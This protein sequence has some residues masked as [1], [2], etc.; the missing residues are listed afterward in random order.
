M[1]SYIL[2]IFI[3]IFIFINMLALVGCVQR[4]IPI[5][6]SYP[7][8]TQQKMQSAHHWEVLAEDVAKRLKKTIDIT[9]P[10]ALVK[11]S[12]VIMNPKQ[13][14]TPFVKAFFNL[15]TTKLVQQG[16][17]VFKEKSDYEDN[18][19]LDYKINVIHHKDRRLTYFPPGMLTTLFGGV[20]MVNQ[21]VDHWKY[22]G[23]AALPFTLVGDISSAVKYAL[24]GETNTEMIITTSVTKNQQHIFGDSRV[25]YIND[26]D[27]DHYEAIKTYQVVNQ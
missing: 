3:F 2:F 8:T 13:Q 14:K 7:T 26:G 16:L 17:V 12:L 27:Y 10:N 24:P 9:F 18:L 19:I 5:A 22:S 25:Y 15:L 1:K 11:P 6:T 4:P 21:A 20:W 23:L